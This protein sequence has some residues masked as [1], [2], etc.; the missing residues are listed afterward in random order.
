MM[1]RGNQGQAI[2]RGDPDRKLFLETLAEG[3]EKTDWQVHEE[4]NGGVA[5]LDQPASAPGR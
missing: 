2:F 1:S 3:C 5:G 4:A